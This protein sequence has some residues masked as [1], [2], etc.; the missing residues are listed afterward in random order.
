[1]HQT[2]G[3]WKLGLLLS[4]TTALMWGL[5][6]IAIKELL[7]AMDPWTITFY[8]FIGAAFL[9][10]IYLIKKKQIPSI[11]KFTRPVSGLLLIGIFG[12][13]ANYIFFLFG[14]NLTTSTT[15]QVLIQLAPMLLLF[16][17][18]Y[19]FKETFS[20]IQWLGFAIFIVGLMLFFNEKLSLLFQASS[21]YALGVF[22]IVIASITW[23]AYALAQKQLLNHFT[24]I[25]IMF[26][27]LVIGSVGFFP[28]AQ[29]QQIYQLDALGIG[30]LIFS[31][32]NTAIAYGAFAEA[33]N[34]W[35][36][37]RVSAILSLTP[38]ITVISLELLSTFFEDYFTME[39]LSTLTLFGIL[40]VVSGSMLTALGKSSRSPDKGLNVT[41]QPTADL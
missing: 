21:H 23:A 25:T 27:I 6:P 11:K 14:L 1:M 26:I 15:T 19:I 31:S 22:Y 39:P 13:C 7:K 3:H 40:V 37:S 5:L 16:G 28:V 29:L 17:G 33:L 41:E 24:S 30:M 10:G 18:L 2:S 9:M 32:L 4:L 12:L 34:H 35:E 8:R 20:R 38:V 36:A